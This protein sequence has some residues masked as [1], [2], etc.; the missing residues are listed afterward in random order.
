MTPIQRAMCD[1][2]AAMMRE[3]YKDPEND[4]KFQE[5]KRSRERGCASQPAS[6][7]AVSSASDSVA[8]RN[9]FIL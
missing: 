3:F 2:C 5:W 4:R 6:E 1:E 9:G 7:S 8:K